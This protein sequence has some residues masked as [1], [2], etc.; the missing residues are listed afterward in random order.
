MSPSVLALI[1]LLLAPVHPPTAPLHEHVGPPFRFVVLGHV[2]GGVRGGMNLK[3]AEL[4]RE[5]RR[6]NP[7]CIVLTGDIVW[8]DYQSWPPD[9]ARV[10]GEWQE[11]DSAMATLDVPVFRVPGN[12]DLHDPITREIWWRRYGSLPRAVEV[13]GNRFLLLRSAHIRAA[14]DTAPP[15]FI[16]GVDLDSTQLDFLRRE[17]SRDDVTGRT[18]V[19]VHHLLWWEPDDGAWWRDV[20]PLLTG[21][22]DAVFS[23]DFGPLKFSNL[24]RDGVR[25]YQTS[26]EDSIPVVMQRNL[27]SNRVLAS[28]FD[29]FLEVESGA[30]GVTVRVHV[31]AAESSG[32]FTPGRFAEVTRPAP[33]EPLWRRLLRQ[34]RRPDR[35]L[36]LLGGTGTLLWLG[37]LLG[38]RS[39]R[40]RAGSARH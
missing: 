7:E 26:F 25:Y 40:G 18:F 29:N 38:R 24:E 37:F 20:H 11:I 2:R 8:G 19:F 22:V 31:F 21:R 30:E 17:L 3:L 9:S 10:E 34:L 28:Q 16:R 14:A 35:A 1:A 27:V 15:K 4:L 12:H 39:A 33:P 32:Q 6:L 5:V 23:G 36:L 13:G